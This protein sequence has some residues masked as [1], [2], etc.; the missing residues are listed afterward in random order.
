MAEPNRDTGSQD[1]IDDALRLVD[2]LQRKLII[3]GVR[4]GVSSV[5]APP[6]AKD[7]VW[8]EAVRLEQP[9]PEQEPLDRLAGIVRTAAPEVV[10]HLGKAGAALFGAL[11]ETWDVVERSLEKQRME[12]EHREREGAGPR[13]ADLGDGGAAAPEGEAGAAEPGRTP[14]V[15]RELP[16][17]EPDGPSSGRN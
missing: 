1:I 3:A 13:G 7:D 10:G 11:G 14:D 8:G 5:T 15:P 16:D 12:R 6:P 17:G 4:R 2:A 9:Q